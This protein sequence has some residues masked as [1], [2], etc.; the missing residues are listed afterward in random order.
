MESTE[1]APPAPSAVPDPPVR[2]SF[3]QV[4]KLFDRPRKVAIIAELLST[5]ITAEAMAEKL[6]AECNY[7]ITVSQVQGWRQAYAG[8]ARELLK[9]RGENEIIKR[10]LAMPD[11][12]V[13]IPTPSDKRA[14]RRVFS[15]K[16]KILYAVRFRK[17]KLPLKQ[18]AEQFGISKS[19]LERWVRD[20]GKIEAHKRSGIVRGASS[21]T[22]LEDAIKL[23]T[24][25]RVA[26]G[27]RPSEIARELKVHASSIKNW[28]AKY[29]PNEKWPKQST[30]AVKHDGAVKPRNI[31]DTRASAAVARVAAGELISDVAADLE[32]GPGTVR[33][34][35]ETLKRNKNWPNQYGPK[36]IGTKRQ[37]G[38][39]K[40]TR[41]RMSIR[42]AVLSNSR[43]LTAR[44]ELVNAPEEINGNHQPITTGKATHDA[45]IFLQLAR[46]EYMKQVKAGKLR[47]D[48]PVMLFPMLALHT[49]SK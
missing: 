34:W 12:T 8:E 13:K 10:E 46:D 22:Q 25:K 47:V 42:E 20:F 23:K 6:S 27:E 45:L 18:A 7:I 48:D 24:L 31:M 26:A 29:R 38:P 35:W 32:V 9:S 49:L 4:R 11:P 33:S 36:H 39:Q 17:L 28:W 44:Q 14:R 21:S 43:V 3:A 41:D 40:K 30:A 16:E 1:T 15:D 5:D 37:H 2:P 19:S